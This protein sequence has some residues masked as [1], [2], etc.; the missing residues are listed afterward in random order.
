MSAAPRSPSPSS[1]SSP[2]RAGPAQS[3]SGALR[4]ADRLC[5]TGMEMSA[6]QSRKVISDFFG[7]NKKMTSTKEVKDPQKGI[8]AAVWHLMCRKSYQ[9]AKYLADKSALAHCHFYLDNLTNQLV[10]IQLWRPEATFQ[11]QLQAA[12]K[13]RLD[14]YHTTLRRNGND[15][16]AAQASA[17]IAEKTNKKG[18]PVPLTNV[19]AVKMNHAEHIDAHFAGDGKT[20]KFLLDD[21]LPWISQQVES[22]DM[23]HLPPVEFLINDQVPGET[24]ND[25]ANNYDRW[26]SYTDN[27]D[28]EPNDVAENTAANISASSSKKRKLDAKDGAE[29]SS[30][31]PAKK[32]KVVL[33]VTRKQPSPKITIN[34]RKYSA[35]LTNSSP[36]QTADFSTPS[37]KRTVSAKTPSP[38]ITINPRKY[39]AISTNSSPEQ[40]SDFSTPLKKRK[41]SAKNPSPTITINPRKYSAVASNTSSEPAADL[42]TPSK[43]RE[44]SAKTPSPTITINPRKYFATFFNTSSEPAADLSTLSKK[45][46]A[47]SDDMDLLNPPKKRAQR[48]STL[49][50]SMQ[51]AEA[52]S[53]LPLY[54]PPPP[55]VREPRFNT[56]EL[57]LYIPPPPI[58][59]EPQIVTP[60]QPKARSSTE[61]SPKQQTNSANKPPIMARGMVFAS[62]KTYDYDSDDYESDDYETDDE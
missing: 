6:G 39:S 40:A 35:V 14:D 5:S 27:A 46:K 9:R 20:I 62:A 42:S 22:G 51:R 54:I 7:R 60:E 30:P 47:D 23:T 15:Q 52:V 31:T 61:S 17:T 8:P 43:K 18:K 25:P 41:V 58:A 56:P 3:A 21:F 59:R 50:V 12:A 2:E 19:Q 4:C 57:P 53:A 48:E 37:K 1:S 28:E 44:V 26:C 29:E 49:P 34:P 13:K 10:R 33:K 38:T 11:V 36:E 32:A 55:I 16:A 24:V 45:R